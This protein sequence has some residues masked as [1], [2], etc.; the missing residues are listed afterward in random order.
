LSCLFGFFS[1]GSD[2]GSQKLQSE[3]SNE[4]VQSHFLESGLVRYRT[5]AAKSKRF[6]GS[7]RKVTLMQLRF[8]RPLAAMGIAVASMAALAN[9]AQAQS[10]TPCSSRYSL[11]WEMPLRSSDVGRPVTEV[12]KRSEFST[13]RNLFGDRS[14]VA[15]G[16]APDGTVA[17][18]MNIPK[19]ENRTSTFF[20]DPLGRKGVEAACLS[21]RIFFENGFEWATGGGGTKLGFGLWGGDAASKLSGGTRPSDQLGWSVRN[22]NSSYGFRLYSYHLNRPGAHG[23]QGGSGLARWGSSDWRPGQW[24][25]VDLEVVMNDVGRNNGY[26]QL[27]LNGKHRQNMT[28][29]RFRNN[30]DWAVRGLYF[31]DIWGG[32]TSDPDFWSPKAQK[33]WYADYKIYTQSGATVSRS[34]PPDTSTNTSTNTA[35]SSNQSSRSGGSFGAVAPSGTVNGSSISVQWS[36]DSSADRYY[37][38]VVDTRSRSAVFGGSTWPNRSCSGSACSLSI[39]SLPRGQYEWMVRPIVGSTTGS[40]SRMSFTVGDVSARSSAPSSSSTA[41]VAESQSSSGGDSSFGPIAP[42]GTVDKG[43]TVV[44][45]WS[46]TGGAV[47]YYVKVVDTRSRSAVFGG[48]ARPSQN[49]SGSTCK[50]NIGSLSRG[51]Y[52]WMVRPVFGSTVGD[53]ERLSFEVS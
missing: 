50:L 16:R 15:I 52:E 26:A 25:D 3:C 9:A 43:S 40:Y 44:A 20:L 18:Q 34:S 51:Q 42:S 35:T 30:S 8:S 38:K 47:R 41:S 33:M 24:H 37:V 23:Q 11:A 31:S 5:T 12:L 14:R 36:A 22:V 1:F 48:T 46:P 27:W 53:Y 17:V 32:K 6:V 49:C 2:A 45:Q 7:T 4:K 39:G 29:L 13:V 21:L 19:G 28:N 10:S